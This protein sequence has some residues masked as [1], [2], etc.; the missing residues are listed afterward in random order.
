MRNS[1]FGSEVT[2]YASDRTGAELHEGE[3]SV[4]LFANPLGKNKWK[5]QRQSWDGAAKGRV[6]Q[7]PCLTGSRYKVRPGATSAMK[8]CPGLRPCPVWLQEWGFSLVSGPSKPG[9][10]PDIRRFPRKSL[11]L[12]HPGS[13]VNASERRGQ[14]LL[15]CRIGGSGVG[16]DISG[17]WPV[18]EMG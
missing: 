4:V 16:M 8:H 10:V 9:Q 17:F 3:P 12:P 15:C 2:G 14:A 11:S 6:G 18:A 7:V 1:C 13:Q 5:G